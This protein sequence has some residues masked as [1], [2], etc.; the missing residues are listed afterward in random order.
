MTVRVR[1][2]EQT[3]EQDDEDAMLLTCLNLKVL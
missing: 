3:K 2:G 1:E